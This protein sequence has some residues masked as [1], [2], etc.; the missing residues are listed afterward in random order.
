VRHAVNGTTGGVGGIENRETGS[1]KDKYIKWKNKKKC[2]NGTGH[3]YI[4]RVYEGPNWDIKVR[5][6]ERRGP[7]LFGQHVTSKKKTFSV[8]ELGRS[9]VSQILRR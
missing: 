6:E 5:G 9:G 4:R 7:I 1:K 8:G 2:N 3:R